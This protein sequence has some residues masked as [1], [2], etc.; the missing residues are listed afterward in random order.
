M[1]VRG[2]DPVPCALTFS[3]A[4]AMR[5]RDLLD[6]VTL[7]ALWGASFLFMRHAAPAFGPIALVQVRVTIAAAV[8]SILL[9]LR[10]DRAA[11]RSHAAALG[12]VGVMNSALPF[13]LFTYATLYVTGGF[14]AI[15]NSTT[16]MWTALVGWVWLRERIRPL[17]WLGL[18]IGAAGVAGLLWGRLDFRLG[19][20]QWQVTLAIGAALL[21]ALA[22]GTS[23]TFAR[24]RLAG[25]PALVVATGSQIAATVLLLPLAATAWPEHTPGIAAWA[26]AIALAV[27]CTALAY[28]LYF[29]LIARVGAVRAAAVT[30][31][32][33]VFATFWGGIFLAE[34]VTLQMLASGCV[35][36]TGTALALKLIDTSNLRRGSARPTAD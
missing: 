29:R 16:P 15:L 11:L 12:F 20:T 1:A 35:I 18:G 30:F 19:S 23:A 13:V 8:L 7:A 14:A 10:G 26:S 22:Y 3:T 17:Q 21:G 28:L 5:A 36:L 31:L 33:P 34:E 6:L 27:V 24:K 9:L 4:S 2:V 25:V 32:V